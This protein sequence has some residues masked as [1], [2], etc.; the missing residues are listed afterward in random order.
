MSLGIVVFHLKNENNTSD[1]YR[2]GHEKNNY[3]IYTKTL[4]LVLDTL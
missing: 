4:I 1:I 2:Q 3:S